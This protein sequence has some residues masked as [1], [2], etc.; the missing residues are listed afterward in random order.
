MNVCKDKKDDV[1]LACY[2]SMCALLKIQEA[3]LIMFA[4]ASALG[5]DENIKNLEDEI[6]HVSM[7]QTNIL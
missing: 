5:L 4:R 7:K 6:I 2:E 3:K 1:S